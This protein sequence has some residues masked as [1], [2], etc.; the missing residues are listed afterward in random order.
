MPTL[1]D[2]GLRSKSRGAEF[3]SNQPGEASGWSFSLLSLTRER[4]RRQPLDPR[5]A[6][7]QPSRGCGDTMRGPLGSSWR[8]F[9]HAGR[10]TY[11]WQTSEPSLRLQE[12]QLQVCTGHFGLFSPSMS[13]SKPT[14]F[15]ILNFVATLCIM[16]LTKI[17]FH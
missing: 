15:S 4:V 6:A 2:K 8:K 13:V 17:R 3:K 10:G 12:A 11:E 14:T 1:S 7:A 16:G 9:G 5:Q